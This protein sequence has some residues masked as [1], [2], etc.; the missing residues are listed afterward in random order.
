MA[1]CFRLNGPMD[2]RPCSPADF[3]LIAAATPADADITRAHFAQHQAKTATYLVAWEG[4]TPLGGGL[5]Q[6]RGCVGERARAAYPDAA[7][8]NHLQIYPDAR[9][10]GAGTAIICAAEALAAERGIRQLAVGVAE[11]NPDA[12]RL[13]LRLGYRET[14]VVDCSEY[15]WKDESG[16]EHHTVE[17][18]QVLIKELPAPG[19]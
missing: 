1:G 8:L 6:W 15:D 14:G 16:T 7:E 4:E 10:R 13:Y 19:A 17:R 11:D 12:Q 9:G 2:V 18:D 5:V 3:P